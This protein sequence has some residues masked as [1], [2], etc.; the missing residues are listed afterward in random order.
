MVSLQLGVSE[1][2]RSRHSDGSKFSNFVQIQIIEELYNSTTQ[3]EIE[4][5]IK[6]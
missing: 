5:N 6:L 2:T 1:S 3:D 4:T